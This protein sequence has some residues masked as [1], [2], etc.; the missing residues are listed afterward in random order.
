MNRADLRVGGRWYAA[1]LSD[2]RN[3]AGMLGIWFS[4]VGL[5]LYLSYFG[6][7]ILEQSTIAANILNATLSTLQALF[8][9]VLW[10]ASV[11]ATPGVLLIVGAVVFLLG[12]K[13]KC[14]PK[15]AFVSDLAHLCRHS[16]SIF[17]VYD[18][19]STGAFTFILWLSL[20]HHKETSAS[21]W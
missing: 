16:R 7:N 12:Y 8:I 17:L 11:I 18:T 5:E 1:D 15:R 21:L 3:V 19:I 4:I 6:I 9:M 2:E 20:L 10:L 14:R 13:A